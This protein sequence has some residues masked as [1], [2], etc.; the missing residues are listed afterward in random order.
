M[1]GLFRVCPE[2]H[3][4]T[5]PQ[6]INQQ[7]LHH[8]MLQVLCENRGLSGYY[9]FTKVPYL[10]SWCKKKKKKTKRSEQEAPTFLYPTL[11]S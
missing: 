2:D 3:F 10:E 9:S 7:V 11:T 1:R 4:I 6:D 8:Q 5:I